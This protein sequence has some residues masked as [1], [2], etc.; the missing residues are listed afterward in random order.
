VAEL[1]GDLQSQLKDF[2]RAGRVGEGG[3]R[4]IFRR[5]DFRNGVFRPLVV[6]GHL[7]QN[8]RGASRFF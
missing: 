2:F 3:H 1:V 4:R 7:A 6:D 8:R 5:H